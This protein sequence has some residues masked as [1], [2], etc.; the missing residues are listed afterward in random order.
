MEEYWTSQS[1]DTM[2]GTSRVVAD[3]KT[4]HCEFMWL[5]IQEKTATLSV[6][7]PRRSNEWIT[8]RLTAVEPNKALF[9]NPEHQGLTMMTIARKGDELTTVISGVRNGAPYEEIIHLRKVKR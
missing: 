4:V 3:G 1:G 7:L 9:Q 2:L 6:Q 8:Y 5:Q